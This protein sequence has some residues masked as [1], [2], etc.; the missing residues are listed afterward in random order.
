ML[1]RYIENRSMQC[2]LSRDEIKKRGGCVG[3]LVDM[4]AEGDRE[5]EVLPL[6]FWEEAPEQRAE[7][8]N[9]VMRFSE[10]LLRLELPKADH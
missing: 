2:W 3:E 6:L 4:L 1:R 7:K 10:D 8:E 5:I 9:R